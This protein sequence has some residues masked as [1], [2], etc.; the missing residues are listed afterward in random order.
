MFEKFK[1]KFSHETHP[2]RD[3]LFGSFGKLKD[4]VKRKPKKS[5]EE[6]DLE[7]EHYLESTGMPK[8]L[9]KLVFK[10]QVDMIYE[11]EE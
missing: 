1:S 10:D 11:N 4:R 8:W 3:K 5:E 6:K 9:G 2:H 7:A